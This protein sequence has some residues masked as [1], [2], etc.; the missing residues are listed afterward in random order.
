MLQQVRFRSARHALRYMEIHLRKSVINNYR[1]IILC[2]LIALY[3]AAAFAVA[4]HATLVRAASLYL[5]PDTNSAKLSEVER[6]RELIIL[7][8]CRH[9]VRG[10]GMIGD[11]RLG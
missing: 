9:L 8:T 6:G 3:S 7:D 11:E 5:S 2:S 10:E 4:E 1:G